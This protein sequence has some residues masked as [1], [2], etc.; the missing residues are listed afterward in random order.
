MW[1][2]AEKRESEMVI[3]EGVALTT[4]ARLFPFWGKECGNSY[5][6][7]VSG[8]PATAQNRITCHW[9]Q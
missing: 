8:V 6:I 9:F 2:A 1:Q 4:E 3:Q 7:V 5:G